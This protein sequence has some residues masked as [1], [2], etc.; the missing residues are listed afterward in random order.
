M[1]WAPSRF[2]VELDHALRGRV[3]NGGRSFALRVQETADF[4]HALACEALDDERAQHAGVGAPPNAEADASRAAR[5]FAREEI[6]L[7][8]GVPATALSIGKQGRIPVLIAPVLIG[9]DGLPGRADLSLS[10][11]GR[12][13]AYACELAPARAA[14]AA[15]LAS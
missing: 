10:H 13:V 7:L 3:V 9:T 14:A 15:R 8:L 6:S 5:D 11:H 4:V 12:F 2:E 1:V